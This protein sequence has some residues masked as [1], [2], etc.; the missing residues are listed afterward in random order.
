MSYLFLTSHEFSV[1]VCVW[2]GVQVG[3]LVRASSSKGASKLD[4]CY[5]FGIWQMS[6]LASFLFDALFIMDRVLKSWKWPGP[7][8]ILSNIALLLGYET[9]IFLTS[10]HFFSDCIFSI[11]VLSHDKPLILKSQCMM[12]TIFKSKYHVGCS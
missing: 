4:T 6:Q 3:H 11:S 12:S 10:G 2:V 1:N 7:F 8:W 9:A 5:F